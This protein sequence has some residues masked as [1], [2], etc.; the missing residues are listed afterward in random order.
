MAALADPHTHRGTR[1]PRLWSI[2][3][4]IPMP[5]RGISVAN[6]I[7]TGATLKTWAILRAQSFR[8]QNSRRHLDASQIGWYFHFNHFG[9]SMTKKAKPRPT[10][11]H[12]D[13]R[14]DALNKN[15]G[16]SG[17]NAVNAKVHGNRG[18]QLDPNR[19]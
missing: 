15:R 11:Q 16:T 2:D 12:L 14:A 13:D 17:T 4:A 3:P 7:D 18:K 10:Q 6:A 8:R 19:R 1:F 9:A 5:P